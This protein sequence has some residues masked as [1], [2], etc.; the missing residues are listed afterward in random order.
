MKKA[1]LSAILLFL[2]GIAAH[3]QN[4]TVHGTVLS[5]SDGEPLIGATVLSDA[6]KN[7]ASAD[8]DGNF[9]LS[10]PEGSKITVSYIGY[11]AQTVT[12]QPEMTI[13]LDENSDVLDE[14]VVVGYQTVRKADL[15][16]AVSVM[17]M[18]EPIS[19]ASSNIMSSLEGK[20]P[21]VQVNVGSAPGSIG[22]IRIRGL[23]TVNGTD[24]L[25][26]VD[27]V[28]IDN[29]G[30][31][32]PDDIE[33]MQV[34]K[35]AASASIYGARAAN[36][37]VI[38]TTKTG[39]AGKTSVN[40][41]YAA[42]LSTVARRYETLD[43]Q[44][45]GNVYLKACQNAHVSPSNP[46]YTYNGNTATLNVPGK[47]ADWKGTDW[48]DA[49]YR[50]AWTN[51]LTASVSHNS[52]K[53]SFMF[54]G[55]YV[56]QQGTVDENFYRRYSARVNGTYN[57]NKYVTVGENLMVGYLQDL[58][59]DTDAARGIPMSAM[60]Q[61]PAMTI[62]NA[63]GTYTQ[64]SVLGSD[65]ANPVQ[66]LRNCR[67]NIK[68]TWRIFG[69]AYLA[70]HP[71]DGLTIKTNFGLDHWQDFTKSLNRATSTSAAD[72]D[73]DDGETEAPRLFNNSM[74][75]KYVECN[76]WTWT[77]TANYVKSFND[78]HHINALIGSEAIKYD[79]QDIVAARKEYAFET[80]NYM[81]IGSGDPTT[82]TNGGGKAQWALFSLF[83]KADYNYADRYLASVTVRRDASSRLNSKN[84]SAWF[85][86]VTFAWRPSAE[87]FFPENNIVNDLKVRVGWGQNGNAGIG[88]YYAYQS[89]YAYNGG[90]G[91]YNVD[92]TPGNLISGVTV[93]STGTS[94]LKWETTTQTNVGVDL[95]ML[96]GQI[97]L[98]ADYYFKKTTDMLTQPPT[99]AVQGAAADV[100]MNTGDMENQGWEVT[101]GYNSPI[102][103]DFS[104]NGSFNI[105]GYKNKLVKYYGDSFTDLGDVSLVTGKPVGIYYGYVCDGIFQNPQEV[106]NHAYQIGGAPGR[107]KYR[108]LNGD[109]EI[110]EADRCFIGD[111]N[112]DCALGL[113]LGAKWK[114]LSLDMFFTGEFGFDI[115]NRMK[116]QTNFF[117]DMAAYTNRSTNI[118][119]AWTETNTKTDVPAVNINDVN[120]EGRM[121]TYF[122]ENGS[123]F[124]MKYIKLSYA[125]PQKVCKAIS[126]TNI[127]FFA[128][129]ENIF[130]ITKY[131]GLDPEVPL[132]SY[133]SRLDNGPYPRSRSFSLGVNLG[134]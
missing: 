108:D 78:K 71:I 60:R 94:N 112:P 116:W 127:S 123:Y 7:G 70:I 39:K 88:D 82:A 114:G 3:A 52:E 91:A 58:G 36:G 64:P 34:L 131:S 4:I 66:T 2:V 57:F 19:E 48:Q 44:Q 24:P 93:A 68:N 9:T 72:S 85:P 11:V 47:P 43:A 42:S 33:T 121:S 10:V 122:V 54:S 87:A 21:G 30:S 79:I 77:N 75:R 37:V 117:N 118:L 8:I 113:N 67:D 16:G 105:S 25:Y 81:Q 20:M 6:T 125:L 111:P 84:N 83:A 40:I 132:G 59:V 133:G 12:A 120:N 124:K 101:I 110:T 90:N 41:N 128:Q 13:Y 130:T 95:S 29:L 73:I 49:C 45:W 109:G 107:L 15:T 31:I 35:D 56:N 98:S 53:G 38:I 96:N 14:V 92:G 80:D 55:N 32:N 69:N 1:I 89:T 115:I 27:G 5:K 50:D 103:G 129:V 100:W 99:L 62:H 46:L 104:W 18:K 61:H 23:G 22:S 17:N 119:N 86:A 51:N 65:L 102:Y 97:N 106:A 26:I 74:E 134:F 28:S 126:A 63:D 76:T